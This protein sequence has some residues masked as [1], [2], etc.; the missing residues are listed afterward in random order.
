MKRIVF[1]IFMIFSLCRAA[2]V[3][4]DVCIEP[5]GPLTDSYK[6]TFSNA[7]GSEEVVIDKESAEITLDDGI[8][9]ISC[10][11]SEN[12]NILRVENNRIT[13]KKD[14]PLK[15]SVSEAKAGIMYIRPELPEGFR[16]SLEMRFKDTAEGSVYF[17]K[18]NE[19]NYPYS[20]WSPMFYWKSM[21]L[22]CGSYEVV[23]CK[24]QS[25][26]KYLYTAI[27]AKT[28]DVFQSW[29]GMIF[30]AVSDKEI[31]EDEAEKVYLEGEGCETPEPD[32]TP[33]THSKKEKDKD[34]GAI[35]LYLF[36][37]E[38]AVLLIMIFAFG[39]L[40]WKKKQNK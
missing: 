30:P 13:V 37:A 27:P 2:P 39:V 31:S 5:S 38:A 25:R 15:I 23:Q 33:G 21:Y 6:L 3:F 29:S 7:Y 28:V 4:A 1:M 17:C 14:E 40:Y 11:P 9:E 16:G 34:N 36:I 20:T 19:Y 35:R 22:P 26:G 12:G 18:I 10:E 32:E 24:T 8:Y